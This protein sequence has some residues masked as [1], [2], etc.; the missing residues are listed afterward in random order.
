MRHPHDR[1]PDFDFLLNTVGQLWLAGVDI[2]W[3][4][5]H[6]RER[7]QRVSLPGYPYQRQRY[8]V[9]PGKPAMAAAPA[10]SNEKN[11]DIADWFYVPS[12]KR[13][14]A[15]E[16]QADPSKTR[17]LIFEDPHDIEPRLAA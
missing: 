10:V 13:A 17:W 9:E 5:F 8:W 7:R 3:S 2:D 6:A 12:W 1:Q 4:G 15:P 16:R 14:H 11:P